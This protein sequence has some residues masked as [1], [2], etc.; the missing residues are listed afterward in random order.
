MKTIKRAHARSAGT[1]TGLPS[2]QDGGN[3]YLLFKLLSLWDSC[4]S[5]WD[6]LRPA[7]E[8]G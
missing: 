5:I 3:K 4:Y 2:L 8:E 1:S 6:G 7:G